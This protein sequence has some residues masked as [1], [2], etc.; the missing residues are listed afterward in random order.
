MSI[1]MADVE[2]ASKA[3]RARKFRLECAILELLF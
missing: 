1:A 3:A 2:N